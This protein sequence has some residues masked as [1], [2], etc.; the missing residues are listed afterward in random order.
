MILQQTLDEEM[1]T[2]KKLTSL[3]EQNINPKATAKA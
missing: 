3:A 2:D 1:T